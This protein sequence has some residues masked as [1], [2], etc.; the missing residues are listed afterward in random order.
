MFVTR[1][2]ERA[3]AS[4]SEREQLD[5]LL[6]VSAPHERVL[7][8]VAGVA[9]LV[10][11]CWMAFGAVTRTLSVDGVLIESGPRYPIVSRS[12]G[13]L[14]TW[15]IA[16]GERLSA[17]DP[18]ARQSVRELE[19]RVAILRELA[20]S[21]GAELGAADGDAP[22]RLEAAVGK[23]LLQLEAERIASAVIASPG[24]G[25]V[26]TL[27]RAPGEALAAG[28]TIAWIRGA[29]ELPP[30]IV[31]PV[32]E[33]VADWIRP[34]MPVTVTIASSWEPARQLTARVAETAVG[35]WPEWLVSGVPA[36]PEGPFRW[37]DFLFDTEDATGVP[38]GTA[39]KVHVPLKPSAPAALLLDALS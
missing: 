37:I 32:A 7:V 15:L 22:A 29:S 5:G 11:L 14:E 26:M 23:L 2:R 28:D 39:V 35:T 20:D 3:T 12:D 1:Y 38:D 17:G 34:G 9:V 6:K 19:R 10:F 24:S 4:R 8:A 13:R 27:L 18:V 36:A 33:D 25:V 21:I 16:P 31:A 30:R